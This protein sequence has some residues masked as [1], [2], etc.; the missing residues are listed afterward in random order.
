MF[1]DQTYFS[2]SVDCQAFTGKRS[3]MSGAFQV[4]TLLS[5]SHLK[6]LII[7]LSALRLVSAFGFILSAVLSD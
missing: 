2:L 7:H 1:N 5:S 4:L 6:P 3:A